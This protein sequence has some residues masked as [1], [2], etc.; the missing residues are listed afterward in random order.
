MQEDELIRAQIQRDME[1]F[2][3]ICANPGVTMSMLSS[4]IGIDRNTIMSHVRVLSQ[5]NLVRMKSVYT[6]GKP[7]MTV[8]PI[9]LKESDV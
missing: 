9:E 1:I 4:I 2:I 8:W 6:G 3:A 5:A 7:S